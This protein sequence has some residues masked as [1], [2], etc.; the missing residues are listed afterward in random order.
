MS[1]SILSVL[2]EVPMTVPDIHRYLDHAVLKPEMTRREVIDAIRLGLDFHVR[3]VCVRPCDIGLAAEMSAGTETEVSCVLAFP[4]GCTSS[5]AKADEAKRYIAA[6]TDEIDMVVNF[7]FVRSG[8]WDDVVTDIRA[9]T[10]VA[11]PAGVLVKVIFETSYLTLDQIKRT[12]ECAIAAGADFVKTSTGFGGEGATVEAVGA[13][14]DAAH[15][16]I[17][18]KPSGGIRDRARAEMFIEMGALRIGNGY[19]STP[20]ICGS[21]EATAVTQEAY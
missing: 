21:P 1:R 11:R 13:M 7:S 14:L 8:M 15:G 3:T 18:V 2:K 20:A 12:T 6:G 5:L 16:R 17:K 19:S 4:H 9:V 10:E